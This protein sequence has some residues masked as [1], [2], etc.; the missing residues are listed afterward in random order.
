[1]LLKKAQE[2]SE[3]KP[4]PA[5]EEKVNT[6]PEAGSGREEMLKAEIKRLEELNKSLTE[7]RDFL[8]ESLKKAQTALDQAQQLQLVTA[9]K[10]PSPPA[11]APGESERG[12]RAWLRS[13]FSKPKQDSQPKA[14]EQ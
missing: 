13:R 12:L 11:L 5:E 1:M 4:Q 6:S 3:E 14:E 10:I 7:E 8:R 2:K 9:S